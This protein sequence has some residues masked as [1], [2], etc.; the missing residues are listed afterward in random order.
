MG[1]ATTAE[2]NGLFPPDFASAERIQIDVGKGPP[3]GFRRPSLGPLEISDGRLFQAEADSDAEFFEAHGFVLLP[4]RTKVQDWDVPSDNPEG[5]DVVRLYYPDIEQLVRHQLLPG[6]SVE[7]HQWSPPLRRGRDTGTPQYA[8]GVHSDY[9][10]TPD[11]F[12]VSVEAYADLRAAKG[13]RRSYERE[14][15]QAF[16]IIDF[17]RPTNMAGPLLHMPLALCDPATVEIADLLP[18]AMTGIAPT[19]RPTHHLALRYNPGQRWYYYPQM[20]TDEVLA[21]KLFECRKDDPDASRF[22]SVFHTA[23]A[24]PKAPLDAEERQSCEHRVGV[25]IL[26]D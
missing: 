13:W 20:R 26:R 8:S 10:L 2:L 24:D 14:Q 18:T 7:V 3:A 25:V 17:W 21:F 4:H 15:V 19:G 23:F 22:R 11:D 9:G 12:E 6:K 1:T 16:M 5:S